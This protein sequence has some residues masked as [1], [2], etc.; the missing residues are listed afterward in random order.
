MGVITNI[1]EA[2]TRR[3]DFNLLHE[4][5]I[6]RLDTMEEEWKK[7]N[8]ID[9]LFNRTS[10][11]KL[12]ETRTSA[13]G[14]DKV[15][16]EMA[17]G[18]VPKIS[19]AAQ[20]YSKT[21]TYRDFSGG[22]EITKKTLREANKGQVKRDAE[23]FM[24]AW[25]ADQVEFA[26]T[27]LS[28]GLGERINYETANAGISV[29]ELKSADTIDGDVNNV[30]KQW[31]FSNNH[32]TPKVKGRTQVTQSNKFYVNGGLTLGGSD[33]AQLAK[34]ANVLY[35]IKV[36]YMQN[37]KNDTGRYAGINEKLRIVAP[38]NALLK[39]SLMNAVD[40]Q[41]FNVL[42]QNLGA[43]LSYGEFDIE[44]TPYL[45]DKQ[46]FADKMSFYVLAP[47]ASKRLGGPELIERYALTFDIEEL[48]KT[49]N[50]F[51]GATQ[52]FDIDV[53]NFRPIA[54]VTLSVPNGSAGQ[55]DNPDTFTAITPIAT[56]VK[57]VSVVGNVTT[58]DGDSPISKFTVSFD[59]NGGTGTRASIIAESA[60]KINLPNS[61][62]LTAPQG[63]EF[64]GWALTAEAVAG[65]HQA[66][67]EYTVSNN[68]KFYAIW[69]TPE[70]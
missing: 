56:L 14:Y 31:L 32:K 49:H 17:D 23:S 70:A 54:Y 22:F 43:N 28:S 62:G 27:A 40:T 68:V 8:P 12:Q 25:H 55:W 67:D 48:E 39:Q 10:L 63:K 35:Q 2:L 53:E 26:L 66:G 11:D 45:I 46:G 7:K 6:I 69:I 20:G 50:I 30:N 37:Y 36:D 41:T 61:T 4:P 65:T 21:I 58:V 60:D 29:L 59:K 33:P 57:P 1:S 13:V 64:D 24:D 52:G 42:G 3:A 44:C 19:N 18:G 51:Y 47:S 5:L 16:S 34:L 15:M 9:L 38:N